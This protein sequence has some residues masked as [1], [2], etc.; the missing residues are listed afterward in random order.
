ML[1]KQDASG[2]LVWYVRLWHERK[3]RRFGSFTTKS[4]AHDFYEKAKQEQKSGQFFPE[5]N[6]RASAGPVQSLL[7]DYM[8]TT[9]GKRAVRRERD[10]ARWWGNWF[11]G[12][13]T[14]A[15]QPRTIEKA[16]LDLLKGDRARATVN[17]YT[18]WL[19]HV[20]NWTIRQRRLRENPVLPIERYPEAEP[21]PHPHS[22]DQKARLIAELNPE[23]VDILRLAVLTGL[24]QAN[25]FS[26]RKDQVNLEQG[27][28][29]IPLTE[30][31]KPRIVHLSEEAKGILR[32]RMARHLDSPWVFPGT[33]KQ[34][35]PPNPGGGI[36]DALSPPV[37]G[38]A[39]RPVTSVCYGMP[40]VIPSAVG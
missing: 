35:R 30:N 28:L 13:C 4:E 18:D 24:R 8:A 36:T 32:R 10:F 17:R 22:L 14:T 12:L 34:S 1:P 21:L 6:Q 15:L 27:I 26:L 25:Q 5:R 3:E 16:R 20:L 39:S 29:V 33:V 2:R 38:R 11:K 37:C 40:C 31:R 19:R 23:E 7:D 9:F